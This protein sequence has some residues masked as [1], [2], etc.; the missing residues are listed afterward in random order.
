MFLMQAANLIEVARTLGSSRRRAF[1]T[2]ALPLARP[3]IAVGL[4][5]ALLEAVNDIGAAEFLGVRTITVSIYSTWVTRSDLPGAAQIALA[6]LAAILLIVVL[7]R[8]ARQQ[9][10][11]ANDAQHP[12]P[13][14]PHRLTGWRA[15]LAFVAGSLPPAIGFAVPAWYLIDETIARVRFAGVSPVILG[16]TVNT[17]TVAAIA[18]GVTVTI[19]VI[20]AYAARV[21]SGRWSTTISRAASLGYAV[22]GTVLAIGILPVVGGV[23]SILD[24]ISLRITGASVGLLLLGSGVALIYAYAA[25]FLAIAVGG[26]ES[27]LSRISPSLDAAARTMGES[28]L[29]RLRRLHLPLARPAVTAAALLVFV[30]C[31]KELPATLMLRPLGFETLATH[32][33]GEAARGTYE[34]AAVAAL[35]IVV[36]GLVPVILLARTNRSEAGGV[37]GG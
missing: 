20:V 16:E 37:I 28:A 1:L 7:E 18:T 31:M 11:Y 14:E 27:G 29:G 26:V 25:R 35:M 22:P 17:V 3:A 32:L 24:A 19:G 13:L 23:E 6:M 2:V 30:D 21:S 10:Q 9:R 8:R 33:Y 12:R 15:G 34:D 36:A 4:S 5:L